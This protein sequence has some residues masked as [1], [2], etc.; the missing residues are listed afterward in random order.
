[1]DASTLICRVPGCGGPASGTC[2]NN[3]SF[4]ECPDVITRHN[5]IAE[6][7]ELP[8]SLSPSIPS[9]SMR[10]TVVTG[11]ESSFDAISCDR[12][13]RKKGGTVIGI[14]AG[15][16]VGKTTLISALYEHI[17]RGKINQVR[18]A[19]SE[20]LRGYEERCHLSRLASNGSKPDTVRTP[21][22]SKL[23]FTH[24]RIDFESNI[25]DIIFSDRSGEHFDNVLN[26]P[27]TISEF[28]EL[29]R[30]DVIL[31]IVDLHSFHSK[32]HE[33]TSR[34]RRLVMAMQGARQLENK[35]VCVVGTKA[36]L[37]ESEDELNL[38]TAALQKLAEDLSSRADGT[39][40]T[41]LVVASRRG[42]GPASAG[43]G[44]DQLLNLINQPAHLPLPYTESSWPGSP[45]ELDLL[46]RPFRGT[47]K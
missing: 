7:V 24:L 46:M 5:E 1:M 34:M 33:Q 4:E 20:T 45:T 26:R 6:T 18:F 10:E 42:N 15:P 43:Q 47:K 23:R 36:D 35:T 39:T 40:I 37:M 25:R 8:V 22:S 3:L 11:G 31:L 27:P 2:I 21:T 41:S 44:Y 38:V 9:S 32:P 29:V 16:D 14:V 28:S 19:G 12:F 17:T 13:L 30:S